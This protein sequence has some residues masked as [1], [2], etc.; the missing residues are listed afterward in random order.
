M[1]ELWR[2]LIVLGASSAVTL[3]ALQ[4][5]RGIDELVASNGDV[6][7]PVAAARGG[8]LPKPI[9]NA[10]GMTSIYQLSQLE[11]LQSTLYYVDESYVD[12]SRVDHAEMYAHA[13]DAVEARVPAVMFRREPGGNLLHVDVGELRTVIEVGDLTETKALLRELRR[14]AA[15]LEENL[16][17]DDIPTDEDTVGSPYAQ[18][19]YAI[20]NGC[21]ETLDPHSRLLPPEAAR[22]M[23]VENQGEFGG[24]GIT[25]K[26]DN[27]RLVVEF[28]MPD[29]PAAKAGVQ[30]N[31]RIL[32]IDGVSTINMDID[33]A[34]AKLR[35]PV[36]KAVEIE[37]QRVGQDD[38]IKLRI[39]RDVI[40]LKP[41]ESQLLEGN[42]GVIQI[43]GYHAQVAEELHKVLPKL[44]KA[45]GPG[46]L[47]GLIIDERGNP[48]GFLKQAIDVADTFLSSGTI[49]SQV[50]GAGRQVDF[51]D[52]DNDGTEPT[53]P[54]VVLVDAGSASASEIVAGAL[55][56]NERA[57][58]VGART[59]GKGSV[60]NLH[61]LAD[62]SKLKLTISQY[63][64]P[65]ERSIQAVGIPADIEL[66]PSVVE[67]VKDEAGVPRPG[68]APRA[69]LFYSERV[70]R[71][72][73]QDQH[74]VQ[75]TARYED[76]A[77][78]L[79]YLRPY[80][81]PARKGPELDVSQDLEVK[82]ARDLL[83]SANSPRRADILA[84]AAP[85]VARYEKAQARELEKA[86]TAEL[87]VDWTN[88]PVVA[89][90]KV[91]VDF[92]LGPDGKLVAGAEEKVAVV[93]KNVG[94]KPLYRVS[95]VAAFDD[96]YLAREFFFGR[97]DPGQ[98][99]RYEVPVELLR[100]HPT[101][102]LPVKISVRQG[103]AKPFLAETALVP[104]QGTELPRLEWQVSVTDADADKIVEVG[105]KITLQL[106]VENLGA[107]RTGSM[108][109]TLRNKSGN[110]LDILRGGLSPGVVVD[111]AGK[112]CVPVEA[113]L[114][115]GVVVGDPAT[116]HGRVER[117][118]EPKWP[119]GC[120]RRAI[121]AGARWQGTFEVQIK[122]AGKLDLELELLDSDAYDYGTVARNEFYSFFNQ[123]QRIVLDVGQAPPTIGRTAPPKISITKAPEVRS[124]DGVVTLSGVVSDESGL[125]WVMVWQGDQKVFYQ[126]AVGDKKLRSMPFTADLKLVPGP[127]TISV[128]VKDDNEQHTS[129]SV[130]TFYAP[131][132]TVGQ[133][134]TIKTGLPGGAPLRRLP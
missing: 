92:D 4:V 11:L 20:V 125:D 29:M 5:G 81:P 91:E 95:A 131:V 8:L 9:A 73:D 70:H 24:L 124:G 67:R 79:R 17:P 21:L 47:K 99:R 96:D 104:V 85:V 38:P 60:Q 89:A 133:V 71:E 56:N 77:Y 102:V 66:V 46:G 33:E 61:P 120:D 132:E 27:N 57:V 82:F 45:A 127:N 94:D 105:E 3:A 103:D 74:L 55:R 78:S 19:E 83:L 106:S 39:V 10:L 32:R 13:L 90:P 130:V 22:N 35:G 100:G 118:D 54:I 31:D 62:E 129:A 68:M 109:A 87:G 123:K 114:D 18:I 116:S 49:V 119:D 93:V 53:Y 50:D 115:N 1:R 122:E 111:A 112:A 117:G 44:E 72:V 25:I 52:S 2:T 23:D 121:A 98:T 59:Y 30:A 64:T 113:G 26:N 63:L 6:P 84:A 37:I 12:P 42:I 15:L 75:E 128:L 40:K 88:G 36:G 86:F 65:G 108:V 126:G 76:A 58:I 41:I 14:I 69:M 48:G 101:E 7:F 43:Q 16:R 134:T 97:V 34:V 28:P 110:K 51:A 80:D 107:G